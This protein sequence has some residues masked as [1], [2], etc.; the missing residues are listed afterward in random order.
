MPNCWTG[1]ARSGSCPRSST[2]PA[3]RRGEL[4]FYGASEA[5]P[6]DS[7]SLPD[8]R[9]LRVVRQP[10]PLGG[11]LLLFS[12]ITDELKLRSRFNA[13][14][15]VQTRDAGQAERRRRRVRLGRA[16][17]AAQ[18]GVRDLLEPVGRRSWTRPA[19]F[20][21]VAELCQGR[22]CPIRPCGWG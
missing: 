22:P 3:G 12:D 18:R 20:D 19:D 5:A 1:C 6:D 10:H 2:T 9:T 21:A 11:I 13:Q 15:Q 4:D 7:W 8:G 17:A 16:A 14:I